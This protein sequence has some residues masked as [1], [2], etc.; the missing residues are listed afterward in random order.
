MSNKK[1]L[2][3]RIFVI[4]SAVVIL[5][6]GIWLN[7]F[8]ASL[9]EEPPQKEPEES[10]RFVETQK[11]AYRDVQVV[12][13]A[14]GRVL[15]GQNVTLT[16]EVQGKLLEG[17]IPL[18]PGQSFNK[19]QVLYRID[20]AEA[21]FSLSAQKSQ[22]YNA[23]ASILPDIK[24]DHE[25]AYPKWKAYFDQ[26]DEDKKLPALP[27]VDDSSLKT[28][29]ATRN[30]YNLFYNIQSGEE[31]LEK[32]TFEAPFDGNFSMV[33]VEAGSVVNP[34]AVI[35]RVIRTRNLEVEV[36][37]KAE[38]VKW[39]SQGQNMDVVL[40]EGGQL[41]G[42]VTRISDFIDPNTQSINVYV[43][44]NPKPEDEVFEGMYLDVRFPGK[45]VEKA[46]QV[47]RKAIFNG[48]DVFILSDSNTLVMRPVEVKRWSND[49][50]IIT[51]LNAGETMVAQALVNAREGMRV[52]P[53]IK[54][55][56]GKE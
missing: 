44:I 15:S 49:S 51:G 26:L 28:F 35:G 45:V 25:E 53:I 8:L 50:A 20:D 32:Y 54:S 47:P 7:M 38:D 3:R 33:N 1:L 11:V 27:Q 24:L 12:V 13:A 2:V 52:E 18:K 9:K 14:S 31:R 10:K 43:T 37:I 16:A 6:G 56:Q 48:G 23:L 19:G 39:L 34:G 42:T 46:L 55:E 4:G 5:G 30:I 29:L 36:P 21:R 22:F 41:K 17:A 40:P